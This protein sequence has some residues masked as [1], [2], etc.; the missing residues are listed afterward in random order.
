[1]A[2][3][4]ETKR[5]AL[6]RSGGRCECARTTHIHYGRCRSA[7]TMSTA[8]FQHITAERVGG[9]DGLS[10]CETLCHECAVG[11]VSYDGN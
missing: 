2:F 8:E 9:S 10:N 5:A 1:M 4:N 11:P 3:S 6:I 7:I